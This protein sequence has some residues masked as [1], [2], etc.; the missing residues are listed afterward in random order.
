QFVQRK[1]FEDITGLSEK[2]CNELGIFRRQLV[3]MAEE[4]TICGIDPRGPPDKARQLF[5]IAC[6]QVGHFAATATKTTMPGGNLRRL[7]ADFNL[8]N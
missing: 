1:R 2:T 8:A 6:D 7:N 3:E 5:Q 4:A